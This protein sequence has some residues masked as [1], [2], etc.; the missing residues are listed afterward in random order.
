MAEM[1]SGDI[2]LTGLPRSG[3]TLVCHL[4]NSLPDAVALVEPMPVHRFAQMASRGAVLDEIA[5]FAA[6]QRATLAAEGLAVT[7]HVGG[8]VQDNLFAPQR[9]ADGLRPFH[10]GHGMVRFGTPLAPDFRLVIKHPAAFTA[11]LPDLA[12]RFSCYA[13]IRNPLPVLASW[14]ST[15][16]PVNTGH[17]PAAEQL[18]RRLKDDLAGL[19]DRYDRQLRLLNWY[20]GQYRNHL[21]PG[22]ILR[23]E[24]IVATG[25]AALAAMLESAASL[26]EPLESRNQSAAYDWAGIAPLIDRLLASEG[27]YRAFYTRAEVRGLLG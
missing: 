7:R 24:D 19:G 1:G 16:M 23:Y 17:A 8:K 3:T 21:P 9:A 20:Y 6:T 18:D 26:R 10:A 12:G 2:M 22:R 5:R 4:L 11:L 14:N 15:R 27:H 25:G 13:V